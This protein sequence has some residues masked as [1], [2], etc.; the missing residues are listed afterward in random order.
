M[1]HV[2]KNGKTYEIGELMEVGGETTYEINVI[3]DWQESEPIKIVGF[4][5][6]DYDYDITENYIQEYENGNKNNAV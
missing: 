5:F 2:S 1:E 4:Y 3:M 6:G